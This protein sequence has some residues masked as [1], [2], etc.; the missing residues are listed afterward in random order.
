MKRHN[1]ELAKYRIEKAKEH[2]RSAEDLLKLNHFNDSI[3]RS[4]YAIFS[5]ARAILALRDLDSSKHSG[6]ISLFNQKYIKTKILPVALSKI[7]QEAKTYRE[8]ADYSD[9]IVIAK[10]EIEYQIKNAAV[11]INEIEEKIKK[12]PHNKSI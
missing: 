7:I 10:E 2:L 6:V 4:Y 3:S 12:L 5:A 8:K 11:F 1:V 9:F